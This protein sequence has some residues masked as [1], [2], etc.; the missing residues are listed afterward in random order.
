MRQSFTPGIITAKRPGTCTVC[1]QP[2]HVGQQFYWYGK[3]QGC[4]TWCMDKLGEVPVVKPAVPTVKEYLFADPDGTSKFD[5]LFFETPDQ[6]AAKAIQIASD[7]NVSRIVVARKDEE[8]FLVLFTVNVP[9]PEKLYPKPEVPSVSIPN[10][11]VLFEMPDG[12]EVP[13]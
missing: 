4:H 3:N 2:F 9:Q 1:H 13:F 5:Q 11:G 7:L 12:S 8:K 6:A 10:D